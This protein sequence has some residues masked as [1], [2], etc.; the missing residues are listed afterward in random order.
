MLLDSGADLEAT[1]SWGATALDWA[2][3]MGSTKVADLLL[4]RGANGMNLVAAASLGKLDLVRPSRRSPKQ[5]PR[6]PTI[7]G[8]P[9]PPA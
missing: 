3:T 8:S 5:L 2:A 6:N 7:T 4:A 9:I 1:T